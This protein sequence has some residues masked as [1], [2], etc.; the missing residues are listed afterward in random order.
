MTA[1]LQIWRP[2]SKQLEVVEAVA[3]DDWRH[4]I[5]LRCLE[6]EQKKENGQS[7]WKKNIFVLST[8]LQIMLYYEYWVIGGPRE[9]K[10]RGFNTSYLS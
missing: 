1:K 7:L 9:I 6:Y 8:I 5:L 2:K 10:Q 4:L 3:D